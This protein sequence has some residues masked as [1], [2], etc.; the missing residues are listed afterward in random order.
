MRENKNA[1]LPLHNEGLSGGLCRSTR[2]AANT[3]KVCETMES[4][5]EEAE[6][7]WKDDR[8]SEHSNVNRYEN[9]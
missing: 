5:R 8:Q 6:N 9:Y 1:E 7:P 3:Q 4:S 2:R